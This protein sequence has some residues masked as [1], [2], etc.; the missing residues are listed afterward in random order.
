MLLAPVVSNRKGEHLQL[1]DSLQK[2]GFLRARV[3]GELCELDDPPKLELRKKHNIDVVVDR[4]KVRP[5]LNLRLAESIETALHLSDGIVKIAA[6]DTDSDF[7]EIRF[8]PI[9]PAPSAATRSASWNPGC[10]PST[11]RSA[12]ALI[13]TAS[14][15]C[16]F[17]IPGWWSSRPSSAWPAAPFAAGIAATVITS[18]CCNRWPRISTLTWRFRSASSTPGFRTS[19]STVPTRKYASAIAMNAAI[20]VCKSIP[21]KAFC[22]TSSGAIAIPSPAWCVR[23]WPSSCPTSPARPAWV[24]DSTKPRAT[25]S[26]PGAT[27]PA[28]RACRSMRR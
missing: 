13:A 4:F 10:F 19:S 2:Q 16:S 23:N 6:I 11:V 12:P 24:T 28:S 1:F 15:P 27:W 18:R 17:S 5:D 8:P 26:S 14:A 22:R 25:S 3:N 20:N 21:S 9:S 7:E